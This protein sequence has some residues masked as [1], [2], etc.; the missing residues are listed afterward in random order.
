M[1]RI[2]LFMGLLCFSITVK[3][4]TTLSPGDVAIIGIRTDNTDNF[5]FV[6]L[7][8]LEKD[9]V[10]LFTEEGWLPE[11]E[12][13]TSTGEK[14]I[15]F[16]A[17]TNYTAGTVFTGTDVGFDQN[18]TGLST[19][20]DQIIVF[21]GT[22][23][24]PNFIFA[25]TTNSTVWASLDSEITTNTSGLPK[26]L[27]NGSTAIAAGAGTG[28]TSEYDNIY[29][30]GTTTGNKE[31]LLAA[32]ANPDNWVGDNNESNYEGNIYNTSNFIGTYLSNKK[33]VINGLKITITNGIIKTNKGIISAVY[34]I[35]GH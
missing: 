30:A 14:T 8:D 1:K 7:V 18:F 12:S 35:L 9:T 21:Q 24:N 27:I 32:I 23:L 29:Y 13:L 25:T 19:S 31:V 34:N 16:T 6:S 2:K 15:T 20:G 33:N 3:A 4:Q 10:I 28:L 17:V 11:T 5:A 26:G 22:E